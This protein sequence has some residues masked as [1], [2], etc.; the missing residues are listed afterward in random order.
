MNDICQTTDLDREACWHCQGKPAVPQRVTA[1]TEPGMYPDLPEDVYHGDPNSLSS[2][3]VRTLLQEGGPAKFHAAVREDNDDFDIGTAAHTLLLGA[4]AGIEVID[5][6]TWRSEKA[7][8]AKAKARAAGK[9]PLLTKQYEATKAMVDAA[10][11]RPEVA[12]LFPG[13]PEGVAEMSAYAIDPVTWVFLRARFDYIIFLP[14]RRVLVRDYKTARNASRAGFQRAAAE[15]GY[16]VQFAHYVRVLEALGYI[17]EEF[18]FLAQEKTPP[19]LTSIN[20]FDPAA[21]EAGDRLVTAGARLF[22]ACTASG[23]WPGY[24]DQ[25]NVMSL[26]AWAPKGW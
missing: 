1:P 9:V 13:A 24:G 2:T 7:Q 18:I 25:T 8:T 20:V 23:I 15:H 10:L 12:E 5:F 26:P 11:A 14:D 3:G 21:L 19:Y 4:G 6:K 17:V 16:Y 22:D